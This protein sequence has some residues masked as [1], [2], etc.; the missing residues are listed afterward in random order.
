[1]TTEEQKYIKLIIRKMMKLEKWIGGLD[2]DIVFIYETL[3]K[4]LDIIKEIIKEISKE[5]GKKLVK[6]K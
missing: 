5:K 4:I 3:D 6:Q 1:M 2:E